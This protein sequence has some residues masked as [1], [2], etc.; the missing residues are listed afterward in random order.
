[1]N[2]VREVEGQYGKFRCTF[3]ASGAV[4]FV[5]KD[6]ADILGYSNSRDAL[7]KHVNKN[8]KISTNKNNEEASQNA[9]PPIEDEN[10]HKQYMTW[11][12]ESGFYSLVFG[13][14]LP[15]AVEFKEWVF[16]VVLPSLRKEGCYNMQEDQANGI[17]ATIDHVEQF[18]K[19]VADSILPSD[20]KEAIKDKI[21]TLA[22]IS[23]RNKGTIW[24]LFKD[25]YNRKFHTNLMTSINKYAKY[26]GEKE[27]TIPQYF[28]DIGGLDIIIDILDEMIER[29]TNHGLLRDEIAIKKND[30]DNLV[31]QVKFGKVI[32]DQHETIIDERTLRINQFK[33]AV[34]DIC[35][36]MNYRIQTMIAYK[37]PCVSFKDI[38]NTYREYLIRDNNGFFMVDTNKLENIK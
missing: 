34:Y 16:G 20:K 17:F 21:S 7:Y 38:P 36:I 35:N 31:I 11:I 2:E 27:I 4:W 32:T 3:D 22:R 14:K 10:G 18:A 9:T 26:L 13:S 1:M 12:N 33:Q 25:N 23:G 15:M 28:E 8:N 19:P 37:I 6:I 30:Y 29:E 5:G 24:K